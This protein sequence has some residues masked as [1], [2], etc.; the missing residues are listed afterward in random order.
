LWTNIGIEASNWL[1]TKSTGIK[2]PKNLGFKGK[3]LMKP[4]PASV[5]NPPNKFK[6]SVQPGTGS[7][8]LAAIIE[9]LRIIRGIISFPFYF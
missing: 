8:K 9:G 4:W 1:E 3:S 7:W 5:K 6:L 2:S